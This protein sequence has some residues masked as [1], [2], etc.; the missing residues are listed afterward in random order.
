MLRTMSSTPSSRS[1]IRD[2]HLHEHHLRD[3]AHRYRYQVAFSEVA[4]PASRRRRKRGRRT[5][6]LPG[7]PKSPAL[8]AVS[9]F[10]SLVKGRMAATARRRPK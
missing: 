8:P 6:A 5:S 9:A 4:L 2:Q 3:I 1:W 10:A 7:I